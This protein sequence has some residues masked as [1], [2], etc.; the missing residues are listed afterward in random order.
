MNQK[1]FAK[2][3][4]NESCNSRSNNRF[5]KKECKCK[6]SNRSRITKEN[7]QIDNK[8]E[9]IHLSKKKR[10]YSSRKNKSHQH[11]ASKS[12]ASKIKHQNNKWKPT[13]WLDSIANLMDMSL[14][15]LEELVM[16]REAWHAAVHEVTNSQTGLSD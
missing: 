11:F 14:S 1:I 8:H 4:S 3:L 12:I 7:I 5:K 16:D 6:N 2:K 9:N 10:K 15:K 13:E